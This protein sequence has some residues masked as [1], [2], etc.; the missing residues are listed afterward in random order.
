MAYGSRRYGNARYSF[1][2]IR[3]FFETFTETVVLNSSTSRQVDFKRVYLDE[4]FLQA[5]SSISNSLNRVVS[6]EVFFER[7]S[8]KNIVTSAEDDFYLD[9]AVV[10]NVSVFRDDKV[11]LSDLS[12]KEIARI[13]P[14]EFYLNELGTV[15]YILEYSEEF[16]LE[17][18][19]LSRGDNIVK[20]FIRDFDEDLYINDGEYF[21]SSLRGVQIPEILVEQLERYNMDIEPGEIYNMDID[22]E[23]L[24][25]DIDAE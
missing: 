9:D 7:V 17:D 6:E 25:I 21:L 19:D 3:T 24:G 11:F 16:Y 18:A 5:E 15:G 4:S 12:S 10:K 13:V 20:V 23:E 22:P 1:S 2:A 8:S 14:E